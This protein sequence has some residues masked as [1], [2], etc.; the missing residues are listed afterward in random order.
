V[1]SL[2]VIP[3]AHAVTAP[4]TA[5]YLA[6]AAEVRFGEGFYAPELAEGLPFRWM[7]E[8]AT[9]Q[10]DPESRPRF[11]ELWLHGHFH[12]GSQSLTV[13][14][15]GGATADLGLV[16]GWNRLSLPLAP[17]V[18]RVRLTVNKPFP[19]EYYPGDGRTLAVQVRTA[20]VHA[21]P[22]RHG[23]VARQHANSRANLEELLAG[24]VEL[25]S[26]PP[27]LG[28]D[29]QG[30]CNVKPPCVYCAWDF[31][32]EQEGTNVDVAFTR[33]T[34][35]EWGDLF[36]NS[37][38]LVNCSIGEPF[39]GKNMDELLDAFGDRGKLLEMSTNGQILTDGNIARLLGRNVHLYISLDAATAETYARLR[40]TRW[41][42]LL[43]NIRRL[44]AAKGGP[45][46]LPLIYLVFMPMKANLHEVDAFV[47]LCAELRID[48]LALRPL[49]DLEGLDL[50][51]ERG[52]YTFDYAQEV[53]PWP[54]LVRISGRVAE[55]CDRLGVA[56]SDQLDFGG[57]MESQFEDLYEEGRREAARLFP[58]EKKAAEGPIPSEPAVP[59]AAGPALSAPRAPAAKAVLPTL[60]AERLPACTEP[61]KSLYILRRGIRPCCYGSAEIADT[62]DYRQAWNSP[63]MQAIRRQLLSGTFHRYCFDSPDCPIVKKS[64]EARSLTPREEA[65]RLVRRTWDRFKRSGHPGR[66]YRTAK[67]RWKALRG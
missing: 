64:H 28:I 54:V 49:N 26:T 12:D 31:S 5:P 46:H 65:L 3:S 18:S 39:M 33:E 44:V 27:K 29:I 50:K 4:P 23:H 24:R 1:R 30:A 32:K 59:I 48:R 45:G 17:G 15:L 38:D 63:L 53:L 11:L 7:G 55:L 52:G 9:L 20:S 62:R 14:A 60:G 2:P 67:A 22:A 41:E 47:R 43:S 57:S 13:A 58:D 66:I 16:H 51:W 61:W 36:E 10:F 35:D 34:L 21:D 25:R 56:L 37:Q 42:L 19:R 8:V 40:N 6:T